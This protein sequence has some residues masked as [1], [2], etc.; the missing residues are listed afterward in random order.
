MHDAAAGVWFNEPDANRVLFLL[1]TC[2]PAERVAREA[3]EAV[4]AK[5]LDLAVTSS[6]TASA[7]LRLAEEQTTRAN[8][9]KAQAEEQPT[10]LLSS[11]TFWFAVGMAAGVAA[12]IGVLAATQAI[13]GGL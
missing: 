4:A 2:L 9:W 5:R 3:A 11:G 12:T 1:E 7:A 13:K 6:L 10:G 8:R